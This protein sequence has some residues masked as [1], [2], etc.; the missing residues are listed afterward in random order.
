MQAK[1]VYDGSNRS[2]R[3]L[4]LKGPVMPYCSSNLVQFFEWDS[5]F[6][7]KGAPLY[8]K[9][10][11]SN[12]EYS[13]EIKTSEGRHLKTIRGKTT[14]GYINEEW[15]LIDDGGIRY[16]GG[17]M[18]ASYTITLPDSGQTQTNNGP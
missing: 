4:D 14:N 1:L 12:G 5:V 3:E 16:T 2:L 8:G 11:A 15:N 6:S 18:Q 7:E 13:I 9:L 17:S 10:P